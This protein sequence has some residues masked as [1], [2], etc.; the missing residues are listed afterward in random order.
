MFAAALILLFA[1]QLQQNTP[2]ATAP[3]SVSSMADIELGMSGSLVIAGLTKTGYT[4][5]DVLKA[6]LAE[7]R[8]YAVSR[9][10]KYVG[11]FDVEKGRV[12]AAEIS[13]Y[14]SDM[15][16]AGEKAIG[17]A[18]AMYWIFYDGGVPVAPTG[19]ATETKV[20]RSVASITTKE[21]VLR[22]PGASIRMIFVNSGDGSSYRILLTRPAL[23]QVG[24]AHISVSK[25]APFIRAK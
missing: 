22:D 13:V 12:S 5:N 10:G 2:G 16:A 25:L 14:D 8:H 24:E 23:D 18:E 17:L 21:F 1:T 6:S 20:R 15:K 9:D 11:S 3:K 19:G 4:L 7:G